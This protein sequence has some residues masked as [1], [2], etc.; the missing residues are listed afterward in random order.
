MLIDIVRAVHQQDYK[1][2]LIFENNDEGIVDFR[3]YLTKGGIFDVL[4]DKE[5]FLKF[6]VNKDLGTICWPN[7]LDIAPET[8]YQKMKKSN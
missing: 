3:E 8:L 1:I 2:K 7:G 5:Y 6:H 4:A